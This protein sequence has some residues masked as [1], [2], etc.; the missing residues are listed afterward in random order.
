MLKVQR[1]MSS[2]FY[3]MMDKFV[4]DYLENTLFYSKNANMHEKY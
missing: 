1:F 2:V 3:N 4:L